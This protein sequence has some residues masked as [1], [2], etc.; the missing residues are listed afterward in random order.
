[1]EAVWTSETLVSCHNTESQPRRQ[2]M[3]AAW[4]SETLVSY[5]NTTQ[6]HNPEDR[7][8]RQHG[9]QTLVSCHNTT[10][11]N[12]EVWR[13]REHGPP[14]RWYRTTTLPGITTQ[15]LDLNNGQRSIADTYHTSVGFWRWCVSIER[16]VLL[17]FIHRLVSQ[18][19]EE[20]KTYTKYHNTRIHKIHTRVNY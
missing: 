8:W 6:C 5:N 19:I 7:K 10:R 15:D 18:K 20:L 4:T 14:K 3:E 16:I 1:M 2:K 9:P 17:D 13:W 11:H 12:P